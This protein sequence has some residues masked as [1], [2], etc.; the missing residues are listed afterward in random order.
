MKRYLLFLLIAILLLSGCGKK[1]ISDLEKSSE[2]ITNGNELENWTIEAKTS[3][4]DDSE[5]I[6]FH[7]IIVSEEAESS[8]E[9]DVQ[10]QAEMTQEV[11]NQEMSETPEENVRVQEEKQEEGMDSF[12]ADTALLIENLDDAVQYTFS[13][14]PKTEEDLKALLE[15]HDLNDARN[16]AAF[17]IAALLRY[18]ESPEDGC[19][20]IDVLRGPRLMNDMDK[21]FLKDRLREKRYLPQAYFEGATPENDYTPDTPWVLIVYDDPVAAEEGY[22]YVRLSTTG[23]DSTRRITLRIKDDS[24]YLWEYSSI[25]LGIRLPA[26]EDPWM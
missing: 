24:Y 1:E 9:T 14:L 15:Y 16:T 5:E 17:F 11:I 19:A 22:L 13:D 25:L 12:T 23:A 10:K 4:I 3:S 21:S 6:P 8:K 18:V 2:S 26:S 20:M 7:E